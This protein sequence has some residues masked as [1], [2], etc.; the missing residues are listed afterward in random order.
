MPTV[1]VAFVHAIA[2]AAD[3]TLT[4]EG[5]VLSGSKVIHQLPPLTGDHIDDQSHFGF[6]DLIESRHPDRM[7]LI[8]AYADV[9]DTDDLGVLGL[10]LKS[11]PTLGASLARLELYFRLL[12]DTA[13]YW[14]DKDGGLASLVIESCTPDH[15]ALTLRNECALAAIVRNMRAFVRGDLAL[16]YVTFRHTCP[17]DPARY[18][19]HFGCPVIFNAARDAIAIPARALDLPNRIGDAAISDFLTCH[20]DRELDVASG[21]PPLRAD[22][23]RRLSS[24]LSTGVPQAAT[25]SREMGMS[26]RTFF[27]RLAE[28]GTTY[29]DVVRDV[30][31]RLARDLLERGDCSIAEIAFLTGFAEQSNF[32]RAFKRW[33]GQAPAQYRNS[34]SDRQITS[35]SVVMAG[36]A[37]RLAG[38]ADTVR[39]VGV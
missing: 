14:L 34:V 23:F 11:A 27:R 39:T 32:G 26:E 12:T 36:A 6:I 2:T 15:A 38:G 37:Q 24:A 28:E 18:A 1:T 25:L 29:R 5:Q 8:A 30:Q 20:L 35:R 16:E 10:A 3:L 33:V 21:E 9:I 17:D 4:P 31:I 19:E 22:L 13:A 7:A